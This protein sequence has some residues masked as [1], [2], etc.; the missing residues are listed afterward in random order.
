MNDEDTKPSTPAAK[1]S[2]GEWKL[3]LVRPD[4]TCARPGCGHPR[5]HHFVD[6]KM[7]AH[8]CMSVGCG[9]LAFFVGGPDYDSI[10]D[11]LPGG[12]P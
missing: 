4:A 8:E 5:D 9:C 2:S 12:E 7:L 10:P 6:D 3:G 1:K 11:T